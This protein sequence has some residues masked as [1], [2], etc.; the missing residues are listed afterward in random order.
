MNIKNLNLLVSVLCL[1]LFI[2]TQAAAQTSELKI[3]SQQNGFSGEYV[4]GSAKLF[5]EYQVL[6]KD[7]NIS[8]IKNSENKT[9]IECIRNKDIVTVSIVDVKLTFYID[10]QSIESN[11]SVELSEADK[12][13]LEE[14][15]V[16]E[17]S[18]FIRRLIA[19]LIQQS[20]TVQI[21]RLKGFAIASMVLGDG[22][23]VPESFE[24]KANCKSP[25]LVQMYASFKQ[26]EKPN[27]TKSAAGNLKSATNVDGCMGCC[28]AGCSGCTGCYT[29]ACY[30]HDHCVD[31][32]GHVACLGLLPSAVAS[33]INECINQILE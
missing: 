3:Q 14:F 9:L 1:L 18:A 5:V 22:P 11:K 28:G 13:K 26:G 32:Y 7:S 29:G 25:K 33:I 6:A 30:R 17:D 2:S 12:L 10:K 8:R 20:K 23:G 31:L 21:D 16:S 24:A 19:E 4:S 15:R 27:T